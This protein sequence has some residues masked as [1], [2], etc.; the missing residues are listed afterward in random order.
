MAVDLH[1]HS[2]ASDGSVPPEELME[3]AASHRLATVALTDHD[4]LDGIPAARKAAERVGIDLI[5]GTELSLEYDGGMHLVVL[6]LEP[7]PGP[8]QDRLEWL[9]AGRDERNLAI[10]E[11]LARAGIEITPEELAEQAG[12]GTVGRPH[13]AALM[14]E[15]SYVTSI[16]AAFDLWLARG[17]PAYVER[18]RLSPMEAIALARTSGAVPVLAHP[19]TLGITT[20]AD[21]RAVLHELVDAGLVGLEAYYAGYHR[22]EREGYADLARRFGLVASGGSDFHGDYKPGLQPGVGYGDLYIPSHVVEQLRER[23]A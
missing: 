21:M 11:A 20:A 7:G 5:P 14:V 9:R 8:L 17:R 18:P 19:H 10:L 12:G 16:S 15:K 22:H 3:L 23:A 4:T 2:T 6:W 13:I 1:L